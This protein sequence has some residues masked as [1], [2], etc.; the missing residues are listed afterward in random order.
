M[1][2]VGKSSTTE[3]G[4][5]GAGVGAGLGQREGGAID[6]GGDGFGGR[7]AGF[8]QIGYP[9]KGIGA[10]RIGG[11]RNPSP[12]T[13]DELGDGGRSQILGRDGEG[14]RSRIGDGALKP[15]E[16]RGSNGV[17]ARV[18]DSRPGVLKDLVSVPIGGAAHDRCRDG[19]DRTD[20]AQGVR[21]IDA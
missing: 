1:R 3:S 6:K 20:I 18:V 7:G 19:R 2:Q 13:G 4:L 15:L 16:R 21:A 11:T 17:L 8:V 14:A 12:Q 9:Q 5:E 10:L